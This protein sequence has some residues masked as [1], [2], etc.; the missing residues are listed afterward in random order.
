VKRG[1]TRAAVLRALA[2]AGPAGCSGADL[3]AALAISRTSVWKQVQALRREGYA[4]R[5]RP[6]GG[7]ALEGAAVEA[8]AHLPPT[9]LPYRLH[10]RA[11][12]GSTNDWA[13]ELAAA[14]APE[15]TLC[16]AEA[17]S[18]GRGRRGRSWLSPAGGLYFSLVLRPQLP[19]AAVPRLTL[20]AAVAVARAIGPAAAIK[21]PNDILVDGRKVCGIL[22]ELQA[23]DDLLGAAVLGIGV[24]TADSPDL[25]AVGSAGSLRVPDRALLLRSILLRAPALRRLARPAGGMAP[26][27]LHPGP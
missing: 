13:K 25:A 2:E 7:Y 12:V 19:P 9:R 24:N 23:E 8:V 16:A 26:P 6:G 11:R 3:A 17:Q 22:C 4:I 14:G 5:G 18:A 21:W 15:G 1:Q 27:L 20:M 10:H